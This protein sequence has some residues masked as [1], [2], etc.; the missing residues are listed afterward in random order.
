MDSLAMFDDVT[1]LKFDDAHFHYGIPILFVPSQ[2]HCCSASISWGI[3]VPE[4]LVL[5]GFGYW[6]TI[7]PI[8]A[9]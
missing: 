1:C 2:R 4:M 3:S 6:G 9:R 8:T 7:P 5:F